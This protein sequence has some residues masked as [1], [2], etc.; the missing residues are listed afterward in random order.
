MKTQRFSIHDTEKDFK[1]TKKWFGVRKQ[2]THIY[3][4]LS[5]FEVSLGKQLCYLGLNRVVGTLD[6]LYI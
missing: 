6:Q 2:N 4:C 3:C 5:F 1:K